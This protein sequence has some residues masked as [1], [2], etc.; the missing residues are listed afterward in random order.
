MED[1]F[2]VVDLETTGLLEIGALHIDLKSL[3]VRN[4][5]E[6]IAHFNHNTAQHIDDVVKEMHT[7]N[8][9][10]DA[11]KRSKKALPDVYQEF[12]EWLASCGAEKGN[13]VLCGNS[14]H[15]DRGFLVHR[16]SGSHR[17]QTQLHYRMVDVRSLV[18]ATEAWTSDKRPDSAASTHRAFTDARYSL[19]LMRWVKSVMGGTP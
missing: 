15:F 8:G 5:F 9:L 6:G 13:V 16:S 2:I 10:W 11:C 14:I 7:V 19:E 4:Q 17:V 1:V 12:A 18:Y 3:E